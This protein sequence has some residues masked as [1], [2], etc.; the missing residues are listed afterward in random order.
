MMPGEIHALLGQNGSGKSTFIKVASGYHKPDA[1]SSLYLDGESVELPVSQNFL[2]KFGLTYV[3][4]DLGLID[5][6]T[7]AENIRIGL[8]QGRGLFRCVNWRHEREAAKETLE[9]LGCGLDTQTLVEDLTPV[10]RAYVALARALQGR[11][12][13]R[14]I[15]LLDEATRSLPADA[16]LVVHQA[17]RDVARD[18]GS[19]LLV[20]HRLDEV[21]ELADRVTILRDGR[22]VVSSLPIDMGMTSRDLAS[23][24]LGH[25]LQDMEG[26]GT[27]RM[28]PQIGSSRDNIV[29]KNVSGEHLKNVSLSVSSGEVVGVI[30]P[31]GSG[32]EELPYL[33]SGATKARS[34]S[35]T[36]DGK[37]LNLEDASY[38]EVLRSGVLLVPEERT[39]RGVELSLSITENIS[40]PRLAQK[41]PFWLSNGWQQDD[42]HQVM[43]ALKINNSDANVPVGILS[44]G[45]QQKVLVGKWALCQPR[46]LLLHEPTQG[47][48]VGAR[49]DLLRFVLD[50]ASETKCGVVLVASEPEDLVIACDRILI[51]RN[52]GLEVELRNNFT[53]ET[54]IKAVH[55]GASDDEPAT[56]HYAQNA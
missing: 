51:A 3:H 48:D 39:K 15:L 24:M 33:L 5:T 55:S 12:E 54:I 18:G 10:D 53:A 19:V 13:G 47:V 14:G 16:A 7:V 4:Q 50:L 20:T 28:S 31:A 40:L 32:F 36:F 22:T 11:I 1:G 41:S 8:M 49:R 25:D 37:T 26:T 42:A 43:D 52:G 27:V 34:G 17:V 23:L 6:L 2:K 44:G 30:G 46:L 35:L 29:I 21:L 56:Q 9:S 45:N 38:K